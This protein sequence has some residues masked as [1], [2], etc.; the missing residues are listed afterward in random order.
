M[1]EPH[2][3]LGAALAS[4]AEVD[5]SM[6]AFRE[7]IRLRPDLAAAHKNLAILFDRKQQRAQARRHYER[8]IRLSPAYADARHN[9]GMHLARYGEWQQAS[10]HLL[11]AVK[12]QPSFEPVRLSLA[13]TLIAMGKHGEAIPH[14][15]MLERSKAVEIRDA[16]RELL[17]I[18]QPR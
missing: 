17:K 13:R 7:A 16:A 15:H 9:L 2:L 3:N 1:P 12:L 5:A 6:A 8:A 18:V 4:L 14:L 11:E 10:E